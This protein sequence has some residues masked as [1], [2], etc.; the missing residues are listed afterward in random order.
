MIRYIIIFT[1]ILSSLLSAQEKY[2]IY[3]N[4]K[5]I[6][7]KTALNKS[8]EAYNEALGKLSQHAVERR[9][10]NMGDNIITYEDISISRSYINQLT[11]MGIKII[12]ELNWFNSV[13]AYLSSEQL[14]KVKSLPFV[15]S[16]EPVKKLYFEKPDLTNT[17]L[18][19][20]NYSDSVIN[21]GN[22]FNQLNL[23]DVP[24]VQAK[25]INGKGVIVGIL[26][27][28]FDWKLHESLKD[29]T[30]LAEYDFV[31]NDSITANQSG[32]A[33]DQ[34]RHGT[35]IFSI[36][37]GFYD[38]VM[39]GPAFNASYILAKTENVS[40]ELQVEEDNYAAA[41]IWMESLG[42][43]ITTS[44]LG[45]NTFDS[46]NSYTY[47]DLNGKTTIV[48]KAVNLA[49]LR[50]VST[51][52]A[53]GNEGNTSWKYIIAPADALDIIAVGAVDINGN[54]ASFSSI[55]PTADGRIKPDV[56][57]MGVNV[58]GALAGTVDK[59]GF[60]NGT[61][62]ATPIASGI[63]AL[64]LSK[65]P[66]L[67]NYQIRSIIL[68]TASN[69]ATPNNLIG[70]GIISAKRAIEFPNLEFINN[71]FVLHKAIFND[72]VNP[73]SVKIS[74]SY[75]DVVIPDVLMNNEG[76]NLSYTFSFPQLTF[77]KDIKFYITY[78][79]SLN[80][81]YRSPEQGEYKF[82]YGVN[83]IL[84]NFAPSNRINYNVISDFYPNPFI[85]ASNRNVKLNFLSSGKELFKIAI[86]DASGQQVFEK[87]FLTDI[88]EN[89]FE[90]DGIS[91]HGY[92][93]ASGVYYALI[94]FQGKEFGKKLVLL[95]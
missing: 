82:E 48:T 77:G 86:I 20:I 18:L 62:T 52:T 19:K 8:S 51:F 42:V 85:P 3:F 91:N 53:A 68:E 49:F 25:G 1:I 28:G 55:G 73:G 63:G 17:E 32:D 64:I 71:N 79:D 60:S 10:K 5:G 12:H 67:K 90:W 45:Y 26:D 24:V 95:K 54:H 7:S 87:I 72:K 9:I 93:V 47:S 50:G 74:Y 83:L 57:A 66:Y 61:S 15:K 2:F 41:L 84:L 39:V 58:Y 56:D 31:S 40:S 94:Q 35:F 34:D 44:S 6:D 33:I 16:V 92:L 88:G 65:Y 76:D 36:I 4:D 81:S 29:R 37:A 21:Y 22:S 27:T 78:S 59:Y 46:G 43:D 23:S 38:S 30:V 13:S 75:D 69:S 80:H 70:Y 14:T 89:I 11:S